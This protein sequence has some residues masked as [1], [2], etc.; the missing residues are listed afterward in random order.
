MYIDRIKRFFKQLNIK[1]YLFIYILLQST[2]PFVAMVT[3]R[4]L[5]TYFYM[6]VVVISVLFVLFSCRLLNVREFF[7]LLIPFIVYQVLVMIAWRKADF[8]LTGYQALLFILPVCVGYY[9]IKNGTKFSFYSILLTVLFAVT[10]LTT[11]IGCIRN[12]NAARILAASSSQDADAQ[13]Y[14]WQNIGGYE[15]VYSAVLLYPCAV[16]AFKAKKLNIGIFIGITLL[17]YAL[18]INAEYSLALMFLMVST[19]MLFIRKNV[20]LKKFILLMIIFIAAVILFRT[21]IAALLTRLGGYLG[22][23]GMMEKINVLFLGKDSVEAFDDPRDELYLKSINIFFSSPVFG[24]FITGRSRSGGH[25]FI[26]DNL[27][28]FGLLGGALMFFMYGGIYRVFYRPFSNK[29]GFFIVFWIFLQTLLLSTVNTGM[30]LLNLCVYAP[31]MFLAIYRTEENNEDTVDSKYTPR[32]VR[33]SALPKADQRSL[34]GGAS[35][36][37]RSE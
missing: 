9:Y 27:A 16:L 29:P 4:F 6:G 19:L 12:P 2:V 18:V 11:I 24:T 1:S 33:L 30:W 17:L 3:S 35:E 28:D 31:I 14:W 20:S 13:R 23:E 36:Q 22:N 5:T 10:M 34:D 7:F 32:P 8:L 26:L 21:A 37:Y 25:S 15:F